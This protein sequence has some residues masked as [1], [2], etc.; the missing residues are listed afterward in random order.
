MDFSQ[1][2]KHS[3]G[4]A[5]WDLC[6]TSGLVT[7]RSCSCVR[8]TGAKPGS[9]CGSPE[10]KPYGERHPDTAVALSQWKVQP[11]CDKGRG[12]GSGGGDRYSE[13]NLRSS[14]SSHSL[15][16]LLALRIIQLSRSLQHM[17]LVLTC[18]WKASYSPDIQLGRFFSQGS[19][20]VTC[21]QQTNM[22]KSLGTQK[23][24]NQGPT[25]VSDYIPSFLTITV[26]QGSPR[27]QPQLPTMKTYTLLVLFPSLSHFPASW[28]H[29][30]YQLFTL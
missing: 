5:R 12:W 19:M 30:P 1:S 6:S 3:L 2:C 20:W 17:P 4:K 27:I 11:K 26:S 22:L 21:T 9:T 15:D 25:G 23:H 24:L 28:N 18:V 16:L 8:A 29:Y 7:P 13:N 14:L 10:M